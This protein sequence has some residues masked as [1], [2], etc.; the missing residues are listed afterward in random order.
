MQIRKYQIKKYA[1]NL[2]IST[3]DKSE[4]ITLKFSKNQ[5]NTDLKWEHDKEFEYKNMMYDVV[6]IEYIN[7]SV[8]ILCY[9]DREESSI[10][11]KINCF[12]NHV[13]GNRNKEDRTKEKLLNFSQNLYFS[14]SDFNMY[15]AFKI[16]NILDLYNVYYKNIYIKILK[17]P[18]KTMFFSYTT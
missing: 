6:N 8:L 15:H 2:I 10:K 7:D 17:P 4:F 11:A 9:E 5:L 18:P 12:L 14:I 16:I 1:K 3:C 13:L